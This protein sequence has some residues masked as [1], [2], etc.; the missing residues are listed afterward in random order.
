MIFSILF[1]INKKIKGSYEYIKN[2]NYYST[3]KT[4]Q[5]GV[6]KC[7]SFVHYEYTL[8]TNK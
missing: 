2:K 1:D 4:I 6:R 7:A 5:T 3:R 8:M